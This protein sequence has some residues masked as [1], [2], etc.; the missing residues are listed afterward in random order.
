MK[1]VNSR[2]ARRTAS[3]MVVEVSANAAKV[4]VEAVWTT[5]PCQ[6]VVMEGGKCCPPANA[7][8][9]GGPTRNDSNATWNTRIT[10]ILYALSR[11]LA[12]VVEDG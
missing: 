5:N 8:D 6:I 4:A 9:R 7:A 10:R 1:S 2:N 11:I 12:E 3:G